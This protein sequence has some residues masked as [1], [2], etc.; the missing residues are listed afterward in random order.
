MPEKIRVAV[1]GLGFMGSTHLK[2]YGE[3]P[4]VQVTAVASTDP[5][6]LKGD[7]SE[8]QGN[9]GRPVA[10]IDFSGVRGYSDYRQAIQDD[11]VDAVDLCVPTHRHAPLAIEA[12]RLGKHVLVEKPMALSKAQA[13]ETIAAAKASDR[14]LMVAHV[15]RFV[16]AYVALRNHIQALGPIHAFSLRRR[17]AMPAWAQWH[18]DRTKSGGGAFDL[19]I[20]D[21]DLCLSLFGAPE[22]VS[23]EGYEDMARGI[24]WVTA[25]LYYPGI[26]STTI[27]GGWHASKAYP[28]SM[29]YTVVADGGTLEYSSTGI[30]PTLYKA[31]DGCEA[32]A[33]PEQDEFAA[34]LSYFLECCRTNTPPRMCP[35]EESAMAV[36][37]M[38]QILNA[39]ARRNERIP[40]N[41]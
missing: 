1:V 27:T 35:P 14:I 17:C 40:C 38:H 34:E 19:L 36:E 37:L 15:L 11:T 12:L 13:D 41:L 22:A 31:D 24:D 2:A 32:I 25:H 7:F 29:D 6:K 4:G 8:I 18:L 28:F 3:L 39:R 9:L 21:V 26:A 10:Q 16:P 23:A 20:H 30:P 33:L 5:R